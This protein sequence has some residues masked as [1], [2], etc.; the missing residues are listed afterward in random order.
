MYGHSTT[1]TITGQESTM[2]YP[3]LNSM[4]DIAQA[5]SQFS[6]IPDDDFL[7]LLH[8]QFSPTDSNDHSVSPQS[9]QNLRQSPPSDD[10]SPSPP[11]NAD[12]TSRRQSIHVR[13][14][15]TDDAPLKRKA[16]GDDMEPGPSSK[17]QHTGLSSSSPDL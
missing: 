6:Q 2:N 14:N 5:P 7:A 15:D 16:S 1:R 12:A 9:V 13:P 4:W 8:K 17:N 11:S 10:S 3:S